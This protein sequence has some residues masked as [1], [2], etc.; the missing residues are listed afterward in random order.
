MGIT[1]ASGIDVLIHAGIDTVKL[2][3]QGFEA[4]VETGASVKQGQPIL[5]MDV[6]FVRS[7]GYNPQVMLLL[8]QVP[9]EQVEALEENQ[10]DTC[11]PALIVRR[12]A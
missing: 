4:L 1:S 6:E 11:T 3:G 2:E 9:Q 7:K 5:K 8:P 12:P 10:A